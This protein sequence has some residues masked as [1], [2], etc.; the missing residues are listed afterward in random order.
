[1]TQETLKPCPFC[2]GH[3]RPM[4][5]KV[6]IEGTMGCNEWVT[7]TC[8]MCEINNG[9]K[10][11]FMRPRY[12]MDDVGTLKFMNYGIR[13]GWGPVILDYAKTF[14]LDG[15]KL[16][17]NK[18][19]YHNLFPHYNNRQVYI[20]LDDRT[21][22]AKTPID[23]NGMKDNMTEYDV[24]MNIRPC[25]TKTFQISEFGEIAFCEKVDPIQSKE[26]FLSVADD[27]FYMLVYKI[28]GKYNLN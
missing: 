1:M 2:G 20:F 8:S 12:I 16:I 24:Q 6:G 18:E 25:C 13:R 15:N 27:I 4:K 9:G 10:G 23:S 28:L 11:G 3:A 26:E 19:I 14:K 5:C 22:V 21:F 17:C 7:I